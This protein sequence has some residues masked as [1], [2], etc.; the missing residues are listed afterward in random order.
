ML[1]NTAVCLQGTHI[2]SPSRLGSYQRGQWS[3]RHQVQLFINWLA[4]FQLIRDTIDLWQV[5]W[6]LTVHV[7]NV[8]EPWFGNTLY[9]VHKFQQQCFLSQ[10]FAE[11]FKCCNSN[12]TH[13]L[14]SYG[15]IHK[16]SQLP[17]IYYKN[18]FSWSK[19]FFIWKTV[20]YSGFY[21]IWSGGCI[22]LLLL[23]YQLFISYEFLFCF[24]FCF[25]FS[26]ILPGS[27]HLLECHSIHP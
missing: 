8:I 20:F 13:F 1:R 25:Y 22:L 17:L 14:L 15:H 3:W 12:K 18:I 26:H 19:R 24:L 7:R 11:L 6:K 16:N 5:H 10:L 2:L 4:H 9:I 21:L 23:R 27:M